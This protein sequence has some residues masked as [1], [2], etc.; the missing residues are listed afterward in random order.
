MKTNLIFFFVL[1]SYSSPEEDEEEDDEYTLLSPMVQVKYGVEYDYDEKKFQLFEGEKLFLINKANDDWW[2]CLRLEEN[3]TFFVPAT[4]VKELVVNRALQPP[5][6]PPPPPPSVLK[7]YAHTHGDSKLSSS[8]KPP[9]VKKR[10]FINNATA[11][12]SNLPVEEAIVDSTQIYENL[13]NFNTKDIAEELDDDVD[14]EEASILINSIME[15]LDECLDKEERSSFVH[16]LNSKLGI[17][18]VATNNATSSGKMSSQLHAV[19]QCTLVNSISSPSANLEANAGY[20]SARWPSFCCDCS[21][22]FP[23]RG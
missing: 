12:T 18:N 21:I 11:T 16:S 6:R 9:E 23:N 17:S 10:Q 5:P 15:E 2:L 7:K 20:V 14:D 13:S 19:D 4:Y 3:L 1:L 8:Q 22:L